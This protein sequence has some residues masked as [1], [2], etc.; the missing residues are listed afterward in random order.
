M[1]MNSLTLCVHISEWNIDLKKKS[2]NYIK[3]IHAR[4]KFCV[5]YGALIFAYDF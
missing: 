2:Y 5:L 4:D 1:N 3:T